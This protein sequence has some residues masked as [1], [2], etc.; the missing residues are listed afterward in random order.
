MALRAKQWLRNKEQKRRMKIDQRR[1]EWQFWRDQSIELLDSHIRSGTTILLLEDPPS[2]NMT[3]SGYV[4][5]RTQSKA[6]MVMLYLK[7]MR[8]RDEDPSHFKTGGE[9]RVKSPLKWL[10]L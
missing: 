4:R 8:S 1:Q 5:E 3:V 9:K 7:I 10:N 6:Y 2:S